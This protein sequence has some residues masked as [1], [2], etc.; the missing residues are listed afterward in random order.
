MKR[1]AWLVAVVLLLSPLA[2]VGAAHADDPPDAG[3]DPADATGDS[4]VAGSTVVITG[5]LAG[6]QLAGY[7]YWAFLEGGDVRDPVV[8][9]RSGTYSFTPTLWGKE[10]FSVVFAAS[11]GDT[12]PVLDDPKVTA[13]H[14][15]NDAASHTVAVIS[16][17]RSGKSEEFGFS[18]AVSPTTGQ[19]VVPTQHFTSISGRLTR[20]KRIGSGTLTVYSVRKSAKAIAGYRPPLT[21]LTLSKKTNAFVWPLLMNSTVDYGA[22]STD[23]K[24]ALCFYSQHAHKYQQTCTAGFP[25]VKKSTWITGVST[26]GIHGFSLAVPAAKR[27]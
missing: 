26:H 14:D 3:G 23:R 18:F 10:T 8:V 22:V 6:P 7:T 11:K 9:G 13:Q 12:P 24:W 15:E 5:R 2:A 4:A 17:K 25:W 27:Y 20:A 21:Q 16:H 1:A 19:Y